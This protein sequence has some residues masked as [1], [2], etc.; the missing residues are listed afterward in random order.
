MKKAAVYLRVNQY[1][2][3]NESELNDYKDV[4]ALYSRKHGLI[5]SDFYIDNTGLRDKSISEMKRLC[6]DAS[7]DNI[8]VILILDIFS[9]VKKRDVNE[10]L[11]SLISQYDIHVI[12]I[13]GIINTFKMGKDVLN[14]Y[15]NMRQAM[16]KDHQQN[17]KAGLQQNAHSGLFNGSVAPYGYEC[18]KG[19]LFK[20]EDSSPFIVQNIFKDYLSGIGMD[21]I[22]KRLTIANV[23][24]PSMVAGKSNKSTKWHGST[25]KLILQNKAYIGHLVQMKETTA[26]NSNVR[27]KNDIDDCIIVENTHEPLVSEEDFEKVQKLLMSRKRVSSSKEERLLSGKL[28][29]NDCKS[30]MVFAT[31]R[32]GYICSTYKK[33]G[34]DS[35][36]SHAIKEDVLINKVSNSLKESKYI[37]DTTTDLNR[38]FVLKHI[39]S[40]S[41]MR[42]KSI[43][44]KKI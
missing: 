13:D 29:C 23:P 19:K 9:V 11:C 33:Y 14:G 43:K 36:S 10:M 26:P 39:E 37:K 25:I 38:E 17:V 28:I 6:N 24:T 4:F 3:L 16:I 30:K 34:K 41:V 31:N 18:I 1:T 22:A 40:I 8:D 21:T 7:I 15:L 2:F 44:I 42:D 20:R 27:I 5:I 35:C 32:N 12:S